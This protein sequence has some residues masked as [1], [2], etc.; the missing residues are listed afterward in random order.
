MR[1]T[2]GRAR[3]PADHRA[4]PRTAPREGRAAGLRQ[5]RRP[6]AGRPHGAQRRPR[7]GASWRIS[8]ARPSAASTKRIRSCSNS[9]ARWKARTRPSWRPWD[10]AYYAEKQR[11]ALYDFDEEALRP[12]FPMER[13]V[14]G[15]FDLVH[16]LYG[17]RVEEEIGRAGV[18]C[19]SALLQCPRRGRRLSGR[20]LCRL[21]PARE[22]ARRR[23]DGRPDHRRSR[24]PTA[25]ART[26]D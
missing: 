5:L 14:A 1:A 16:R 21:V 13:V 25:S 4:H 8:R 26:W 7:A 17:I 2:D 20:L 11:A 10:V 12:Y 23:V 15:L 24:R 19:R 18:G 22:Q 3:Q 6:G 9:A